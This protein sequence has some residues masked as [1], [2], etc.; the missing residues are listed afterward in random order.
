MSRLIYCSKIV[1][2]DLSA[3]TFFIISLSPADILKQFFSKNI[4]KITCVKWSETRSWRS[5]GL[6]LGPNC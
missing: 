6:D 1:S 5:V 2:N 3:E 4:S